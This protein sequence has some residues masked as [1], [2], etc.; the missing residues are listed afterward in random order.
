MHI[1]R[2]LLKNDDTRFT[3][4]TMEN[5]TRVKSAASLLQ[6]SLRY[7]EKMNDLRSSPE[8]AYYGLTAY[9]DMLEDEFL[10]QTLLPDL[11]VRGETFLYALY[12]ETSCVEIQLKRNIHVLGNDREDLWYEL[13]TVNANKSTEGDTNTSYI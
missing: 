4:Y 1:V 12:N 11:P 6:R 13:H 9:S 2:N 5:I 3:F 7:I 8:S 10:T